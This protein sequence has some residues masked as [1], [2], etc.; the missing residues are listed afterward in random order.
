MQAPHEA[1]KLFFCFLMPSL[2]A[3]QYDSNNSTS[4][5]KRAREVIPARVNPTKLPERNIWEQPYEK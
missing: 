4:Y 1:A 5:C 2:S 3:R